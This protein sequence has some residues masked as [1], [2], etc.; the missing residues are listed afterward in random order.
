MRYVADHDLH[1]HSHLSLCSDDPAQTP[2]A[3]LNYGVV[4]GYKTLCLTDHMWDEAIPGASRGYVEETFARAQNA[5]PLPRAEG[6]RFLFGS[7][8][9]MDRHFTLGI[10]PATLDKLDFCVISTTHLHMSGFTL[11]GDEDAKERADLWVRRLDSVLDRD[12]PFHK[13]GIGHLTTHLIYTK[14]YL[15]V[16]DLIPERE[17]RRVFKKAA[18]RGVG[19]ELNFRSLEMDGD[20]FEANLRPFRIAKEEGCRFYFGS[21]SHHPDRFSEAKAEFEKTIDG[22]G[23]EESD[24]FAFVATN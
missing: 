7:E 1:I 17:Y 8:V 14:N 6:I 15:A 20:E 9:D 10:T 24:K 19:I 11:E 3:I 21:D 2:E 18:D 5:L 12:L 13:I 16:L 4:S 22:L 23:L